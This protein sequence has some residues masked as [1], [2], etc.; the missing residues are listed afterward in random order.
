MTFLQALPGSLEHLNKAL[1]LQM[2]HCL[3]ASCESWHAGATELLFLDSF[4][5]SQSVFNSKHAS[6]L[7]PLTG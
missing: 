4:L 3:S 2:L 1:L 5:S 6:I 7:T